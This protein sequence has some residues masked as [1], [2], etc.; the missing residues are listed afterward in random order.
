M[1]E[2]IVANELGQFSFLFFFSPFL[3]G[4]AVPRDKSDWTM[5]TRA[6][7]EKKKYLTRNDLG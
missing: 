5:T 1:L 7:E 2:E 6:W 4:N 3:S